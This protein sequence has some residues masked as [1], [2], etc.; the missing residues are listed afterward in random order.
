[1]IAVASDEKRIFTVYDLFA[2]VASSNTCATV[3]LRDQ[4]TTDWYWLC[5]ADGSVYLP[6][7][8]VSKKAER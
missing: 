7:T 3:Y 4:K 2:V 8:S 1:M 6:R 5:I